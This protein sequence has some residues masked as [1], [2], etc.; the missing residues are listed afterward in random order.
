MK[1]SK[2][3]TYHFNHAVKGRKVYTEHV[4]PNQD[5]SF[6]AIIFL[7]RPSS[8]H[9]KAPATPLISATCSTPT[10][11]EHQPESESNG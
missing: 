11:S 7:L 4:H 9:K 10:P 2:V 6:G 5:R 1:S 3:K 8:K